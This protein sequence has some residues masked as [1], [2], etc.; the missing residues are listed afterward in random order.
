M[1][2]S[3]QNGHRLHHGHTAVGRHGLGVISFQDTVIIGLVQGAL[4]PVSFDICKVRKRST[5]R[6]GQTQKE[7]HTEKQGNDSSK[8]LLHFWFL[9]TLGNII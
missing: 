3:A 7:R 8:G 5:G 1:E 2:N 4:C 6:G 9:P